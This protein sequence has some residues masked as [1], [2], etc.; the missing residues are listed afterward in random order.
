MTVRNN[1]YKPLKMFNSKHASELSGA[2]IRN[3]WL[4]KVNARLKLVTASQQ[5]MPNTSFTDSAGLAAGLVATC[6]ICVITFTLPLLLVLCPLFLHI[7]ALLQL[8]TKVKID[9]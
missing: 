7:I 6:V 3:Q 2:N 8:F 4:R 1:I 5:A 9:L